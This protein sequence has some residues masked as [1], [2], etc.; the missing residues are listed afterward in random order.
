MD[1]FD[2]MFLNAPI[3]V[4]KELHRG[5][6]SEFHGHTFQKK[7]ETIYTFCSLQRFLTIVCGFLTCDDVL[8]TLFLNNV[9]TDQTVQTLQL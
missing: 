2:K 9:F 1:N 5:D 8:R 3:P 6:Y 7:P 4:R